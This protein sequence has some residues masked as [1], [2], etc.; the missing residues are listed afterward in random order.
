MKRK[1]NR[2]FDKISS[3]SIGTMVCFIAIYI[4]I[5][6]ISTY[7]M[8]VCQKHLLK[9]IYKD[10]SVTV[11][12]YEEMNHR[13][14]NLCA[15]YETACPSPNYLGSLDVNVNVTSDEL[16]KQT[17]LNFVKNGGWWSPT[18]C[19]QNKSVAIVIPFR[20]RHKHLP[21]LISHLHPILQRQ[22]LHYRIFVVQQDSE[23]A[24]N[25]GQLMNAG[26]HE[27]L[28][29]YPFTCLVL[30]DVDMIPQDDRMDYAC[31]ESPMHI[32]SALDKFNYTNLYEDLFGGVVSF[33]TKDYIEINGFSNLFWSWGGEDDNMYQRIVNTGLIRIRENPDYG[34][35][36]MLKHIDRELIRTTEQIDETNR[37]MEMADEHSDA[38]G[39]NSV[40]YRM[41]GISLEKFYT[42][43]EL[44]L[45]KNSLE[46]DKGLQIYN[47]A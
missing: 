28:K 12:N 19:Y 30:H 41:N 31:A 15:R 43:I 26:V 47:D 22:Q 29:I 1:I 4:V 11:T 45:V 27:I 10:V 24:F 40:V 37:L 16:R 7:S 35:Y 3:P 6:Q 18:S 44:N 23:F 9:T 14:T 46:L 34:R 21:V 32:S 25:K 8:Y 13:I 39:Y 33:T 5:E 2:L 20:N 42:V 17:N 36:T 38:D